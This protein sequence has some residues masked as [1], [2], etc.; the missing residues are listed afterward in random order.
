M[1]VIKSSILVINMKIRIF[2]AF[3][4]LL[5]AVY[6]FIGVVVRVFKIH[7]IDEVSV[8]CFI[9]AGILG[10]LAYGLIS[11]MRRIDKNR[12]INQESEGKRGRIG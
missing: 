6:L 8:I 7:R 9:G 1:I 11:S 12:K 5:V 3:F 10:F 2:L 4:Q